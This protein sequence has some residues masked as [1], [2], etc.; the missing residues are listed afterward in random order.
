M[1]KLEKMRSAIKAREDAQAE[2]VRLER[3]TGM[4]PELADMSD[5]TVKFIHD[6][7]RDEYRSLPDRGSMIH[8]KSIF[9][10]MRR[11]LNARAGFLSK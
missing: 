2:I 5:E 6:E 10:Q 11:E 4:D 1:T 9:Q 7:K 8:A 3:E